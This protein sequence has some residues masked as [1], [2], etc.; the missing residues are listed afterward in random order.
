[1]AGRWC[2]RGGGGGLAGLRLQLCGGLVPSV[3]PVNMQVEFQTVFV[4]RV[5]GASD[6]VHR[7]SCLR[8]WRVSWS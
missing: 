1:M 8:W 2:G 6:P 3:V 7:T 4:V 5:D